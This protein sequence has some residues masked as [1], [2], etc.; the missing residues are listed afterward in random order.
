ML[1]YDAKTASERDQTR[2][3]RFF[4]CQR[5]AL[6]GRKLMYMCAQGMSEGSR[7]FVFF[8]PTSIAATGKVASRIQYL[9]VRRLETLT[10]FYAGARRFYRT[11]GSKTM[12]LVAEQASMRAG[13]IP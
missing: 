5:G 7:T 13:T 9:S 6:G 4:C 12:T 2:G 3:V 8:C 11:S 10:V 1:G